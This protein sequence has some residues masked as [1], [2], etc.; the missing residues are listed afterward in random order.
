MKKCPMPERVFLITKMTEP[1]EAKTEASLIRF[2]LIIVEG[3]EL[4]DILGYHVQAF[5]H[6]LQFPAR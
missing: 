6:Y 2:A 3:S 5:P 4:P 1:L